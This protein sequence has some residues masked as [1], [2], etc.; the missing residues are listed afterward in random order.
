M[1]K[2]VIVIAAVLAFALGTSAQRQEPVVDTLQAKEPAYQLHLSTGTTFASGWGKSDA[3]MWVA[4]SLEL[5]ASDRLTLNVGFSATGSLLAGY[6]L[7]GRGPRSLAPRRRGTRMLSVGVEAEYRAS[8]RLTLW[9]SVWHTG[10]FY[11]PLWSRDS[12]ALRI[13]TT[14]FSGGFAYELSDESFLEMHFHI[15]HDQYGNAALGP[16][17]HPWYGPATPDFELYGGPWPF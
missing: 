12:E 5:R 1:C 4:P 9:G 8:D 6:E 2:K 15:V 17:G 7:Q 10:G 3:W 13:G 16:Y 11:E 14:A